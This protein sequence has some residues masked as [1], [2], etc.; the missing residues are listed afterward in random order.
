[1][2]LSVVSL[3]VSHLH[4]DGSCAADSKH[5]H[6]RTPTG[7]RLE[8]DVKRTQCMSDH[9]AMCR[10]IQIAARCRH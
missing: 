9:N 1:M 3:A 2:I 4:L 5:Q 8:A 10:L 7:L 6:S